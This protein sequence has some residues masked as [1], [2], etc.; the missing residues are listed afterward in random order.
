MKKTML[1]G[2]LFTLICTQLHAEATQQA[3]PSQT[4]DTT[5]STVTTN[6]TPTV[7]QNTPTNQQPAQNP[8]NTQQNQN[9]QPQTT[10]PAQTTTQQPVQNEQSQ[11]TQIAPA[12]PVI[13]CDYKIPAETKTIDQ[14][15]VLTW[16]EN[17]TTQ[18]FDFEPASLDTQLQKLQSCFTTQGWEGFNTALQKSGNIDAIK[19]QNLT[20]SS[21]LDGQAQITSATENEWKITLPL[22]VVY[23]NDK[24]KVTQLLNVKV[25]IGRKITG[26]L[27]IT[28]MIA[29]PKTTVDLPKSNN[30]NTT[31]PTNTPSPNNVDTGTQNPTSN[32]GTSTPATTNTPPTSTN[33]G[34]NQNPNS[35]TT[36]TPPGTSN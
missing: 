31:T 27:G 28:Q 23:Q 16:A 15:L 13:N 21:Q 34:T 10:Q 36:S 6:Q 5:N 26:D 19:T 35:G 9:V 25:T 3:V 30:T 32:A 20:V 12:Q 24:E 17:A 11:T 7:N 2:A 22:Q 18:A 4:P 14:S 8:Q 33:S 29:T 1:W